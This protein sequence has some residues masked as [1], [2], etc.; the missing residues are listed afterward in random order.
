MFPKARTGLEGG[1]E[2]E[3]TDDIDMLWRIWLTH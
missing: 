1:H 2:A 3:G